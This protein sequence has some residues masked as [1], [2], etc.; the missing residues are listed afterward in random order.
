MFPVRSIRPDEWPAYRAVRLRALQDSPDAFG[1]PPAAAAA[2]PD[3]LWASRLAAAAVSGQDLPLFALQADEV[4]GLAWCKV[5]ATEPTVADL[6]QMWVAPPSRGKGIGAALLRE[7]IAF[8]ISAGAQ[9]LRL[10]VAVAESP[11]LR[12][13]RSFGFVP[14]GEP[15]PLRDGSPLWALTMHLRLPAVDGASPALPRP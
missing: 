7:A 11:A 13:Y 10:G 14:V 3:A 2:R 5:S 4:C 8:A 1:S 9:T 15:E 12:L 6:F